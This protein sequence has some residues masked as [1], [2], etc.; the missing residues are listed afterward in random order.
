MPDAV[1]IGAGPNGLVAANVL[2]DAGWSVDVLEAEDEPG[3]AVRTAELIE[4]G[5]KHDLVSAFYPLAAASPAFRRLELERYGLEWCHG[6]L[7]LAHPAQDGSCAVLSRDV[8]ETA[9][10]FDSFA[11]G[12]G[13]SW[14]SLMR[15]WERAADG[16]L[17]GMVTP[18]PAL[19]PTLR[20]AARLGPRGLAELARLGAS[21]VRRFAQEHFD[22]DGAAR[23][24]AGNA[25][26]AD[27]APESPPGAIFG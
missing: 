12:D 19:A 6:P 26:H 9:A 16:V 8:D 25:L 24:L 23:I 11:R 22:G 17:E 4:P 7:V 13:D 3:G 1:V 2:A 21:S 27:L 18:L 10:S 15:M 5:Y 20:L 14:R